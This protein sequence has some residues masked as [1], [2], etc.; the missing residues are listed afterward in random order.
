MSPDILVDCHSSAGTYG[1]LKVAGEDVSVK[2]RREWFRTTVF[3]ASKTFVS[4]WSDSSFVPPLMTLDKL[5]V[6]VM[7]LSHVI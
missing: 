6:G 2:E 3:L 1:R 5:C 7:A 4:K